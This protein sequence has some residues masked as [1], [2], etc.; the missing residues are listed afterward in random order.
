MREHPGTP[1]HDTPEPRRRIMRSIAGRGNKTTEAALATQLRRNA[2]SGWRRHLPLPGRPDFVWRKEKVALFV[3][4]CFWHG[5]PRHYL[6]PRKNIEF[7]QR[8]IETNRARDRRVDRQLR[9]AGWTTLRIWECQVL[10]QRTMTRIR[11]ALRR[12]P[13]SG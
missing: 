12:P 13:T 4:G 9:R 7:W 8:K 5:C 3:D 11:R 1:F 10:E 6:P 2:L